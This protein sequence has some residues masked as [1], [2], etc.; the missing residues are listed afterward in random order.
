M[1]RKPASRSAPARQSLGE[2]GFV[3][4]RGLIALGLC[5]LVCLMMTATLL[6]FL[7]PVAPLGTS[8]RMLTF[9]ERVTYQSAIEEVYW[10]HRIWPKENSSPKP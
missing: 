1:K 7:F 9:E 3:S 10:R 8:K 6:A 2:A 5:A 4:L